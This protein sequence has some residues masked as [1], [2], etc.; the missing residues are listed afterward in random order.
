[1]S[2][3]SVLVIIIVIAALGLLAAARDD[4][5]ELSRLLAA[6]A[7][8]LQGVEPRWQAA[9]ADALLARPCS[10][11]AAGGEGAR[12]LV[13]RLLALPAGAVA[14]RACGSLWAAAAE[15]LIES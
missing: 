5:A 7:A 13:A 1:M 11:A 9:V 2:G 15:R 12:R 8:A 14:L 3:R 6:A 10:A 4:D